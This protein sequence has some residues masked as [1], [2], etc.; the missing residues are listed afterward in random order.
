M[1]H[2]KFWGP[3]WPLIDRGGSP[4]FWPLYKL[5]GRIASRGPILYALMW[6]DWRRLYP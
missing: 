4:C 3:G 1:R 5:R 2:P 6:N